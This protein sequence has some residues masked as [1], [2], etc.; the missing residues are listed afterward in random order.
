MTWAAPIVA[1]MYRFNYALCQKGSRCI[2]L[3]LS[4]Q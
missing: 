4:V 3:S 1:V 2:S